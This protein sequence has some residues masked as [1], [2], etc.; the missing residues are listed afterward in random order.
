[1]Y[2][3]K[4]VFAQVS[5]THVYLY[6]HRD[7]SSDTAARY[8]LGHKVWHTAPPIGK[9]LTIKKVSK[10]YIYV[11]G[12][13]RSGRSIFNQSVLHTYIYFREL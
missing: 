9:S 3:N 8:N 10:S 6:L 7:I 13:G 1:M 12:R 11:K 5:E 2:I 4:S